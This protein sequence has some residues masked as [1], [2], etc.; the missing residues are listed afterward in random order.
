MLATDIS[1]GS[2]LN[3]WVYN[4]ASS[5]TF[6]KNPAMNSL[7]TGTSGIPSG[8]TVVNDGEESGGGSSLTFP[9]TLVE[10][11][12]G[13]LG[14]DVYNYLSTAYPDL[15][16]G[17]QRMSETIII[18]NGSLENKTGSIMTY[19]FYDASRV[20]LQGDGT[21]SDY[22]YLTEDGYLYAYDD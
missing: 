8:W 14:V 17:F 5:G 13:Q 20:L 7:P 15:D 2:C 21:S 1:A 19:V 22:Y 16:L 3:N 4:V 10:G 6:V 11:D 12:N 9:V 18:S